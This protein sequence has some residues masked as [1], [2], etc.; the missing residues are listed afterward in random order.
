MI[1]L[2]IKSTEQGNMTKKAKLVLYTLCIATC[3]IAG[4]LITKQILPA[5][6]TKP[7]TG[8]YEIELQDLDGLPITDYAWGTFTEDEV[9]EME[10]RIVNLSD[11]KTEVTWKLIGSPE[12]V[13]ISV[14]DC[15]GKLPNQWIQGSSKKLK[16]EDYLTIKIRV[17]N[18]NAVAGQGLEFIFRFIS[19]DSKK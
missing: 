19:M 10:G 6:A 11:T 5:Y 2:L 17:H 12:G 15:S 18:I 1:I 8:S 13:E 16:T 14:W 4:S 3:F 9:K 7:G